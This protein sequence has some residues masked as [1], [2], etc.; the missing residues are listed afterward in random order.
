MGLAFSFHLHV[1]PRDQ[2]QVGRLVRQAPFPLSHPTNAGPISIHIALVWMWEVPHGL[3]VDTW[4]SACGAIWEGCGPSRSEA[5]LEEWVTGRWALGD[6]S[7]LYFLS[8]LCFLTT[9]ASHGPPRV[10]CYEGLPNLNSR[11]DQSLPP[12][13]Q[14]LLKSQQQE[15][16]ALQSLKGSCSSTWMLENYKTFQSQHSCSHTKDRETKMI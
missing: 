14:C 9:D 16:W 6:H 7:L 2:T 3:R 4:S 1:G 13:K 5:L 11:A 8:A 12:L 10:P 15:K